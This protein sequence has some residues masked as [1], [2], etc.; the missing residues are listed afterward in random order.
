MAKNHRK[1]VFQII[2]E[3]IK[4]LNTIDRYK[5]Q[6]PS[7]ERY[8]VK[9]GSIIGG[10]MKISLIEPPLHAVGESTDDPHPNRGVCRTL[11][12]VNENSLNVTCTSNNFVENNVLHIEADIG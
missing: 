8:L 10:F 6:L 3:F 1:E 11:F 5:L 12:G 4:L 2:I 7:T 9:Q